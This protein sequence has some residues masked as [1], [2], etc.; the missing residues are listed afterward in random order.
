MTYYDWQI[1][2]FMV[3]SWVSQEARILIHQRDSR[4]SSLLEFT[5]FWQSFHTQSN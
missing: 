2:H 4:V 1:T 3:M 5:E